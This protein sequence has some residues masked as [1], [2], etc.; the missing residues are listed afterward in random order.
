VRSHRPWDGPLHRGPGFQQGAIHRE[1]IVGEQLATLR[2]SPHRLEEAMRDLVIE[3]PLPVL[4]EGGG[5][6]RRV[7]DVHVQ[8]P[9]EEHVVLESFAELA[10]AAHRVE[11][12]QQRRL[13]QPLG[14]D[15]RPAHTRVHGGEVSVKLGERSVDDR[16]DAPDRVI[17]GNQFVG[18]QRGEDLHLLAAVA[19]HVR[20]PAGTSS[21]QDSHTRV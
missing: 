21:R 11:R 17:H 1:V 2:L 19:T 12:D 18:R 16:L 10:L 20:S 4:A 9:L 13:E 8:E 14:S 6:E 15:A 3:E 5:I 7:A